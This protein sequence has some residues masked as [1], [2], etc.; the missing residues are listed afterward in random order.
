MT[1]GKFTLSLRQRDLVMGILLLLLAAVSYALTYYFSGSDFEEIPYDVG[2]NFLP[3]V[4][5]L[6]LAVESAFFIFMSAGRKKGGQKP[7][8]FLQIRP[9]IMLAAF[10][11]YV[12]L[13]TL[14][15]YVASTIAF[16]ALSFYMLGV[17]KIWLL[18]ILPLGI[19]AATYYLFETL[20]DVYLPSGNLF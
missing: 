14:L 16:L 8:P 10:L 2:P 9:V 11:V 7:E 5:L 3:R 20:L 12:Y 17:K 15:G 19:T 13:V 1:E 4:L 6:A 18:L